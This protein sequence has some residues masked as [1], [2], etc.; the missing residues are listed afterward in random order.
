MADVGYAIGGGGPSRS[1]QADQPESQQHWNLSKLKR[2]Y[3]DY[4]GTKRE[5]IDEQQDARR[6][7]HGSHW[8]KEQI[9]VLHARRQPI[10][11]ENIV[12]RKINGIVGTITRLRQDPKAYPRTPQHEAGAELATAALR[13]VLD[14]QEFDAKD[15]VCAEMAAIDGI[16]GIEINL[17]QGDMGDPEIS[18]DP[19]FVEDFFYSPQSKESDFSDAVYMGVGKWLNLEEAIAMFPD[20][21]EQLEGS[22][23]AG[24]ELSSEPDSELH[25]FHT[26]GEIKRVRLVEIWYRHQ[27]TWMFAFFTGAFTIING[28][29]YLKD[30]KGKAVCKYIM[31]SAY[32][33]QD[34]DR[35]GFVRDLKPLNQE[36]NMRKSKALYTMLSRRIIAEQGAFD[37]IE[38][39]RREAARP[40]GVVIRNKGFEAEFDDSS[41]IAETE[42]QFR[43]YEQARAAL[44]SFG[45]NIAVMGQGLEQSSGRAIHLLQQAGLADLGPYIQSYRGWKIRLYRALFSAIQTHWRAERWIRVTDDENISQFVQLNGV[46]VNPQTGLPTL[47]NHIGS[48]DVDIVIDEGPDAVTQMTDAYETLSILASKGAQVPPEVLI[49]LSP[50]PMSV[51][52][53]IMDMLNPP[54]PDP[55]QE[56]RDQLEMQNA[57]AVVAD[58]MA[59]AKLKEAQTIKTMVEAQQPPRMPPMKPTEHPLKTES[60]AADRFASAGLKKAQTFRTFEDAMKV[61]QERMFTPMQPMEIELD[62]LV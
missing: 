35:Y 49:E 5:E 30:E 18:L 43:F 36:V 17:T 44:E 32:V 41:R 31:F 51:K 53:K 15:P 14:Q 26:E 7:R 47:V 24:S 40:D 57:E 27:N 8:T 33:D 39:A 13:Y 2:A 37:D 60:E 54:E 29:S 34:G 56:A 52:Q 6:Y 1:N 3:T 16:G 61:A 45:P 4:L 12:G 38:K 11:H 42:A 55:A 28:E 59:A 22:L 20:H 48:L 25:W 23:E 58:K 19:V 46:G 62:R 21:A 50:L 10:V 9:R